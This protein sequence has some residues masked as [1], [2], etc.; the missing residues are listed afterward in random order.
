MMGFVQAQDY[1]LPQI[2]LSK[3]LHITQGAAAGYVEDKVCAGCHSDKYLS[4]QAI[5]MAQSFKKPAARH[6]I[7]DFNQPPFFHAPS[8]RYYQIKRN[9]DDLTFVRYQKDQQGKQINRFE[10][11]IDYILGSG[12][13]TRSYL[14]QTQAGEIFQLPLGWFSEIQGWEMSPGYE[15]ADHIGVTR[16]VTRECMFCHNAFPEMPKDADWH[17]QPQVFPHQLPQGTG[18]QRCHGPG[19]KHVETVLSG[20]ASR[21][22]IQQAIVN[23]AKLPVNLR[24]SVCFQCHLLPSV[25]LVGPRRFERPEF[26]FR[27]GEDLNDY[28]LHMEV[29]DANIPQQDRFE[30][31]HHGYRFRQ[32]EC[33]VQSEGAMGCINCHD[34]HKK[35]PAEQKVKHFA[36]KCMS[37]HQDKHKPLEQTQKLDDC[38]S[39]H[40]P[41][42]RTQDVIHVTV[43]DHKIGIHTNDGSLVKP[44]TKQEPAIESIDWLLVNDLSP[45]MSKIYQAA[46]L[47]RNLP[48]DNY[49]NALQQTLLKTDLIKQSTS[50]IQPYFDLIVG[51]LKLGQYGEAEN[52]IKYV[53]SQKVDNFRLRQWLAMAYVGQN[54]LDAAKP[55]LEGLLK[56]VKNVPEIPLYYGVL[57]LRQAKNA[58]ALNAFKQ[59]CDIRPVMVTCWYYQGL[60]SQQLGDFAGAMVAFKRMLSID[61]QVAEGYLNIAKILIKQDKPAEAKRY[62]RHG[63]ENVVNKQ[64][65]EKMLKE[66]KTPL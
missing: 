37:C 66:L 26:S 65:L 56:T 43:T 45:S 6:F 11:K 49:L 2:D 7:E 57:L 52:A 13:K 10:R 8:K 31:N 58:Q 25:A 4:Y 50:Q 35:V 1:Q 51:R 5:G 48:N 38:V 62:L 17:W 46:T 32:S 14:F 27:P 61:P 29:T 22:D 15:K 9:G 40:M 20:K 47:S 63:V 44:I 3:P 59:A 12:N 30:I 21:A 28:M 33:Y 41:Q 53:L 55:I 16:Q 24:D 23:P 39:C 64:G 34:V 18:C 42:R 54:K 60:L 36:Q 19:A